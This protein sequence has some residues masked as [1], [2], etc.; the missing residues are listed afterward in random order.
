[1]RLTFENSPNYVSLEPRTFV[2]AG[3]IRYG[4]FKGVLS[5]TTGET[6]VWLDGRSA[7]EGGGAEV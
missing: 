5:I 4:N 1:M 6:F 3:Y 7:D 2:H